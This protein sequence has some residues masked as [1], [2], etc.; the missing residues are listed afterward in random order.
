MP[1]ISADARSLAA[2][3]AGAAPPSPPQHLSRPA[4]AVWREIASSR[5]PDYFDAG[6][7]PLLELYC[8]TTAHSRE[9]AKK[10][11]RFRRANAWGEAKG[12]ERRYALLAA[13]L[14]SVGTKLRLTV[15]SAVS[16][17]SGKL[18]ERG[19]TGDRHD[20]DRLLGGD[21]LRPRKPN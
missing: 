8:E 15:Q 5:P 2:F 18:Q 21:A 14:V 10:L 6:N 12:W 4:A 20:P 19:Q 17:R 16:I 1:R 13:V 11:E 3:R 9:L 7:F